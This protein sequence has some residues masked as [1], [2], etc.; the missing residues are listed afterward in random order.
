MP[1][2]A[3]DFHHYHGNGSGRPAI[4]GTGEWIRILFQEAHLTLKRVEE[5][6]CKTSEW[7]F[8]ECTVVHGYR[9]VV[10]YTECIMLG[11]L[12]SITMLWWTHYKVVP[13]CKWAYRI[14]LA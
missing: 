6:E 4:A 12:S 13:A 2:P 3:D 10:Q 11:I 9:L 14:D 1:S 7:C 8:T 5:H